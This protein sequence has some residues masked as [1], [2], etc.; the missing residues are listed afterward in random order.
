MKIGIIG[1]GNIGGILAKKLRSLGHTV[2][3]SNSR[4]PES[5]KDVAKLTGAIPVSV[6]QSCQK[7]D[8]IIIAI[9]FKSILNLSKSFFDGIDEK[10]I[11]IDMCNYYPKWRDGYISEFNE[12]ITES[13]WVQLHLGKSIIKAF[14]SISF[15]SLD[16]LGKPKGDVERIGIPVAGDNEIKKKIVMD[17]V[18]DL[19]FDPVDGGELKDSWRQQPVTSVYCKDLT[20]NEIKKQLKLMGN[21]RTNEIREA[22]IVNRNTQE[23][24]ILTKIGSVVSKQKL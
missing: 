13:E 11:I 9:P 2:Y 24:Y 19:G 4:G 20:A 10:V 17:L 18:D 12:D 14:N 1:M 23:E 16:G 22:I 8:I 15:L 3:I 21:E 6:R 5:L 7:S